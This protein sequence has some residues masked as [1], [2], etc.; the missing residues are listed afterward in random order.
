MS[1]RG[2][3]RSRGR[4]IA[5]EGREG[6]KEGRGRVPCL[7]EVLDDLRVQNHDPQSFPRLLMFWLAMF[8][9]VLTA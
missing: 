3:D 1:A 4:R 6:F 2:E 7:D 5:T 8:S 9:M